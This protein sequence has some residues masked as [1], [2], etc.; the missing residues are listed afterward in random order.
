[1]TATNDTLYLGIDGG[2]T[3][4]RARLTDNEGNI[5]GYGEAGSA[6]VYQNPEKTLVSIMDAVNLAIK[7]AGLSN[8][9]LKR[10]DAGLGLAGAELKTSQT[11]LNN[12]DHPFNSA[13][14]T[15]DAHIACLGAHEGRDGALLITGTGIAG[16]TIKGDQSKMLSGFGFPLADF[17][18]GAWLGLQTLQ[19]T[20]RVADGIKEASPLTDAILSQFD[21][22]PREITIWS[23]DAKSGDYGKFSKTATEYFAKGDA[24]ATELVNLQVKEVNDMLKVMASGEKSVVMLGGLTSYIIDLLPSETQALLT[25]AKGDALAGALLLAQQ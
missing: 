10:I 6:N 17:G 3:S 18:S 1:M 4:C 16:W 2:G 8:D 11:F 9:D 12:W 20:L 21:N 23:L 5:I 14:F 15:N 19:A 7:E 13:K 24:I 25:D 22:D